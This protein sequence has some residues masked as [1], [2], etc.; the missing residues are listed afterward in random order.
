MLFISLPM[1]IFLFIFSAGLSLGMGITAYRFFITENKISA[2]N[3]LFISICAALFLCL[4]FASVII[5]SR[6]RRSALYRINKLVRVNSAAAIKRFSEFGKLGKFFQSFFENILDISERRAQRIVFLDRA[7]HLV[8]GESNENIAIVNDV[9][10]IKYAAK[11]FEKSNNLEQ[12][13]GT[14]FADLYPGI[15]YDDIF[16]TVSYSRTEHIEKGEKH[17]FRFFPVCEKNNNVRGLFV[18][19]EKNTIISSGSETVKQLY[20]NMTGQDKSESSS[21]GKTAK[22]KKRLLSFFKKH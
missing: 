20:E 6:Q 8:C 9:G 3:F 21:S 4:C 1:F 7:L 19:V 10:E 14:H 11:G 12:G 16:T 13:N 18:I 17:T 15:Q 2:E 5:Y 22:P